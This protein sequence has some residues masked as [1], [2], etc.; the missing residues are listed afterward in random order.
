MA[1]VG[2]VFPDIIAFR[3]PASADAPNLNNYLV[4][5]PSARAPKSIRITDVPPDLQESLAATLRSRTAVG[6]V[7]PGLIV[8]DAHNV[9]SIL[10]ADDQMIFRRLL[11]KELP[12][13]LLVN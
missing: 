9:F 6:D 8:T 13:Q 3:P 7:D 2:S 1:T 11:V 12:P 4:A 10:N 5:M